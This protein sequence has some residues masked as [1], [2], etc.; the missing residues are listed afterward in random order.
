[1]ILLDR[2]EIQNFQNQF[3]RTYKELERLGCSKTILEDS[4]LEELL[5]TSTKSNNKETLKLL[6][7]FYYLGKSK[8]R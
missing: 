2:Q 5:R 1:M 3:D 6:K 4:T 8:G 7:K